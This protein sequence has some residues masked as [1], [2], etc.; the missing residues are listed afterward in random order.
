MHRLVY[1]VTTENE[2]PEGDLNRVKKSAYVVATRACE[3]NVCAALFSAHR[4]I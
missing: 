4:L 3:Y 2:K 1:A